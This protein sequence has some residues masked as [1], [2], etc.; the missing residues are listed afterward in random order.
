MSE[1]RFDPNLLKVPL[2]IAGR[3]IEEVKDA[4]GLG[5]VV[6]L[7]SNESPVGPSPMAVEAAKSMLLEAHRYPGISERDLCRKLAE[8]HQPGLDEHNF[9]LGN[10]GTDVLRMITQAFVFDGGNT[11]MSQTTFPMYR[12]LTSM[13]GGEPRRVP[14]TKDGRQD[15][16]NMLAQIDEDTRLVYLCSPNNPT[17]N[18]ITQKEAAAFMAAVPGHV[19]VLFDESYIDYVTDPEYADSLEYVRGNR[20][21]VTVRSFSK[22]AGLANLRIGYLIGPAGLVEYIR[23]ARLP[24]QTGDIAIAAAAASLDDGDFS[25]HSRQAVLEGRDYLHKAI[26]NL[27]VNCLPSQA[28]FVT[29]LD[30]AI[31]PRTLT[32]ALLHKGFIVRSMEAF[33]LPEGVRVSVGSPDENERFI[34]TLKEVLLE[35]MTVGP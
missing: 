28:N 34:A 12:I 29:I 25:L 7:A 33:G 1:P 20:N 17:G 13:F 9:L 26:S 11:V 27:D 19:V 15:L 10:G 2:Y 30:P 4:Y 24:F 18:I 16:E 32:E 14:Q 22:T 8:I 5:E 21:V 6:K 31:Q 23:H 3:S 35:K